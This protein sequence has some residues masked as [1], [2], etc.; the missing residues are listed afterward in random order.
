MHHL[1]VDPYEPDPGA[2]RQAGDVLRAGGVIAYPTDTLYGLA[3]DPRSEAAVERLFALKQRDPA[4]AIP[5]IAADQEQAATAGKFGPDELKL[6]RALWP[7]PLTIVVRTHPGLVAA[8]TSADGT[9]GI[10]VPAH[11]VARA[12]ARQFGACIT[13]TSANVSGRQPASTADE[14]AAALGDRID[15][16]INAGPVPGGPPSTIVAMRDG[17]PVLLRAGAVAWNRVLESLQ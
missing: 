3:V 7:G 14:A 16:V 2:I 1:I 12:L 5:L 9:V 8:V 6:A 15:L 10:R 17:A 4:S 13:A 11:P